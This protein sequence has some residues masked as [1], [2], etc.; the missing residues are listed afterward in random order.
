M[1]QNVCAAGGTAARRSRISASSASSVLFGE[2][3]LH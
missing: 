2:P 1:S 3:V